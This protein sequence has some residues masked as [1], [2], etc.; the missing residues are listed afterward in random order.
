MD[1]LTFIKILI[2][3]L[4]LDNQERNDQNGNNVVPES[5]R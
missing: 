4:E 1:E 5:Q 3:L 2:R